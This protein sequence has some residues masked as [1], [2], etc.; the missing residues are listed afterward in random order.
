M[1]KVFIEPIKIK[2]DF[3]LNVFTDSDKAAA[4][5]ELNAGRKPMNKLED[6]HN[7]KG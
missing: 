7:D 1:K 3:V 4:T 5:L 2:K 6:N